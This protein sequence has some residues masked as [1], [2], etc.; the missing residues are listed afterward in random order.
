MI[1]RAY[2]PSSRSVR[3]L[4]KMECLTNYGSWGREGEKRGGGG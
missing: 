4:R 3:D 2:N 1:R